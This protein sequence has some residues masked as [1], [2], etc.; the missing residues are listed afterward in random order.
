LLRA[1]LLRLHPKQ[2]PT[3]LLSR[4]FGLT[5]AEPPPC[6]SALSCLMVDSLWGS[7]SSKKMSSA[8]IGAGLCQQI[9]LV[10][11]VQVLAPKSDLLHRLR[12]VCSVQQSRAAQEATTDAISSVVSKRCSSEVGRTIGKN[13][14][15]IV[16]RPVFLTSEGY[17]KCLKGSWCAAELGKYAARKSLYG[18]Q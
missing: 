4:Q 14:R 2:L 17:G 7:A 16:E 1:Q 18:E 12:F 15:S 3:R 8:K 13:S 10:L 6:L 11:V 9:R 5:P